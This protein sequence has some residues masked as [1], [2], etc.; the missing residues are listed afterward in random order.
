MNSSIDVIR[1]YT[2]PWPV[3]NPKRYYA[4]FWEKRF[5]Q[6]IEEY[7]S[8]HDVRTRGQRIAV[9]YD[10][11]GELHIINCSDSDLEKRIRGYMERWYDWVCKKEFDEPQAAYSIALLLEPYKNRNSR[12]LVGISLKVCFYL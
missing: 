8:S 4:E 12:F 10:A 11:S 6:E 5:A 1:R 3:D 2:K 9:Y 7:H